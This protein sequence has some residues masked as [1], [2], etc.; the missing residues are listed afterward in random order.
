MT[1]LA[2]YIKI[3]QKPKFTTRKVNRCAMC[4]RRRWYLRKFGLCRIC[5][6]NLASTGNIPGLK[7]ASW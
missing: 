7:K 4:G 6:R 2:Q 5:L 3:K 1:T